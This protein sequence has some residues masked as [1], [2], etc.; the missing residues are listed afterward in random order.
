MRADLEPEAEDL[1]GGEQDTPLQGEGRS[2]QIS[3]RVGKGE[4]F[5]L[6]VF[7]FNESWGVK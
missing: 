5:C 4:V 7:A 1:W 3:K 2:W 6:F